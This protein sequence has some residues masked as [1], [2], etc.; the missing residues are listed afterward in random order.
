MVFLHHSILC[1]SQP[2][3]P[4]GGERLIPGNSAVLSWDDSTFAGP[5]NIYLWNG[6]SSSRT[7]LALNYTSS[8]HS[9]LWNI[10]TGLQ[11]SFFR[12]LI[13]ST[14]DSTDHFRTPS[15][16]S[17]GIPYP[18]NGT[19]SSISTPLSPSIISLFPSPANQILCVTTSS[20][21]LYKL[22]IVNCSTGVSESISGTVQC[23]DIRSIPIQ[24]LTTGTYILYGLTE[25]G[26]LEQKKFAVVR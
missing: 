17:I 19:E 1:L 21:I 15:F 9:F 13:V 11:G 2:I 10:P 7:P 23:S 20:E 3:Y 16:F 6:S 14:L 8:N 4:Y 25:S 22:Y 12:I 26:R 24:H 18:K 5:V